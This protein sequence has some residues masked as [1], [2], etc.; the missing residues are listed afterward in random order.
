MRRIKRRIFAGAVC[1]QEIY[2]V[3]DGATLET[4]RD[5]D[6]PLP[7]FKDEA[8][9]AAH[10]LGIA[11]RRHTRI[12]NASFDP[13]SRYS[14]LTFDNESE[15]HTFEEA[16][17]IRNNFVR[18]LQYAYPDARI[19][20]YMGRG[21]HTARIHMHMV[22]AGIPEEYICKQWLEGDVTRIDTL[23]EH[24]YY[25]GED[26][27]ADYTGLANYLFDHW[28]EEQGPRRYK[29]TRNMIRP[30]PETPTEPKREYSPKHPPAPPK[31]YKYVG[32]QQ[33]PYGYQRY[34]YVRI[35]APPRAG[36]RRS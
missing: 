35:P 6:P 34:V 23:R 17:R 28:T 3:R 8:E 18:R 27:G 2:S 19:A 14:T 20:I 26:H 1:E 33:T 22:S 9:R 36:R 21:K 12:F 11:R 32:M 24:N 13:Q 31:G 25:D 15:V 10:R 30:R 29:M 5:K 7:R 4:L 16:L